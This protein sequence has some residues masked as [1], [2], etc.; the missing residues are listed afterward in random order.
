MTHTDK[1]TLGGHQFKI[2]TNQELQFLDGTMNRFSQRLSNFQVD[3]TNA[4]RLKF[5]ING[6]A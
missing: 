6:L 5:E 1:T 4:H 2:N 3:K